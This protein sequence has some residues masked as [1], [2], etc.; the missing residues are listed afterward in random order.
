MTFIRLGEKEGWE[1][2]GI[3]YGYNVIKE[4]AIIEDFM[5]KKWRPSSYKLT[6]SVI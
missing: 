5:A 3:S 4:L 1:I 2:G 6:K